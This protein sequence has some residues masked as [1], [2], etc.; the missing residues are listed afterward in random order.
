V[1]LPR[2]QPQLFMNETHGRSLLL[3][4]VPGV[5]KTMIATAVATACDGAFFN[6]DS[7]V[8]NMFQG[9]SERNIRDTFA[10]AAAY[11]VQRET[12]LFVDEIDGYV[13]ERAKGDSDS[14]WRIKTTFL[15]SFSGAIKQPKLIIVG[16]TNFPEEIESGMM[17]RF[18]DHIYVPLPN[19]EGRRII[20]AKALPDLDAE[21]VLQFAE[22]TEMYSGSDLVRWVRG[23]RDFCKAE[24]TKATLFHKT[25]DGTYALDPEDAPLDV[26]VEEVV[27]CSLWEVPDG[28]LLKHQFRASHMRAV[29]DK[30]RAN[31]TPETLARL[32][33]YHLSR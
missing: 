23:A 30:Y 27:V 10:A 5:G 1:E 7:A 16:G 4:G 9:E 3:Y 17:R 8:V 14:T 18:D 6:L 33:N 2:K 15:T 13:R 22:E 25:S 19:I 32:E 20:L 21:D 11:A 12:V 31:T 28:K 29:R 24:G 26:A